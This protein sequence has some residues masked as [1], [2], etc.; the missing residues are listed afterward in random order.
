[1]LLVA[2]IILLN[3]LN[4]NSIYMPL[5]NFST[6]HKHLSHEIEEHTI[7]SSGDNDVVANEIVKDDLSKLAN[8]I[9]GIGQDMA[10]AGNVMV[11]LDKNGAS[12]VQ[13]IL[14]KL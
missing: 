3:L 11:V 8:V 7:A 10:T 13:G 4:L 12:I 9:S 14:Y 6:D 5:F 1:M 2:F